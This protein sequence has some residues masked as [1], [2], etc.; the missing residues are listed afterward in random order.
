MTLTDADLEAFRGM[1]SQGRRQQEQA[2][3]DRNRQLHLN[4][5]RRSTYN[6]VSPDRERVRQLGGDVVGTTPLST[7]ARTDA[8]NRQA[9][10]VRSDGDFDV[11]GDPDDLAEE[12]EQLGTPDAVSIAKSRRAPQLPPG[13]PHQRLA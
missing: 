12:N 9:H 6:E 13:W 2:E 4:A 5:V 1:G 10:A 7:W 8:R 11:F 3:F